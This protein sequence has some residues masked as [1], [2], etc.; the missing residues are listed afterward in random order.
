MTSL[1]LDKN[2]GQ[3]EVHQWSSENAAQTLKQQEPHSH[4]PP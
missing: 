3:M 4:A 1:G 2:E